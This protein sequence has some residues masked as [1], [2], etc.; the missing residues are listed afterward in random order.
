MSVESKTQRYNQLY[1]PLIAVGLYSSLSIFP[2]V[3]AIWTEWTWFNLHPLVMSLA[4]VPLSGMATLLKKIGGYE[5]TKTHGLLLSLSAW[6]AGF[7]L[8]VIYSNKEARGAPHFQTTHGQL[9]LAVVVAYFGL[10]LFGGLLLHPDFGLPAY[11][12]N[13]TLRAVHKYFGRLVMALAWFTVFT[14][15]STVQREVTWQAALALPL[16]GMSYFVLL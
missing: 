15:Y 4:F 3:S 7:G 2:S 13:A 16:L 12:S 5:N 1:Y 14:G 11:R 9:G 8:Y 6:L 10:M